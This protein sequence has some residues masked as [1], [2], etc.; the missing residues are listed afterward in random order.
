MTLASFADVA[1][2]EQLQGAAEALFVCIAHTCHGDAAFEQLQ[3]AAEVLF[4]CI[5]HTCH[6]DAAFDAEPL[7]ELNSAKR[8]AHHAYAAY[9]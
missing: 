7:D 9:Q 4:V 2:A 3:G 8:A 1:A 5:A 6:G